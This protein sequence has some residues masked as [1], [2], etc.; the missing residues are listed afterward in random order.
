M[1]R[2][3]DD[4]EKDFLEEI[5]K[6]L[7]AY[8]IKKHYTQKQLAKE[9][10]ISSDDISRYENGKTNI[11]ILTLKKFCD[12]YKISILSFLYKIKGDKNYIR[13]A[14]IEEIKKLLTTISSKLSEIDI[15]DSTLWCNNL[16]NVNKKGTSYF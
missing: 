3:Y 7:K 11:D 12:F 16:K 10:K 14:N 13:N 4:N 5:G 9:L 1:G 8:R 2:K 15:N 6:Q